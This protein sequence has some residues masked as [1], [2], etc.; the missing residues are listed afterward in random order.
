MFIVLLKNYI[1]LLLNLVQSL[2]SIYFNILS[3]V[4]SL[5]YSYGNLTP[6]RTNFHILSQF[7]DLSC[8]LLKTSQLKPIIIFPFLLPWDLF[9]PNKYLARSASLRLFQT[10]QL[11]ASAVQSHGLCLVRLTK[12]LT[13]SLGPIGA[14]KPRASKGYTLWSCPWCHCIPEPSSQCTLLTVARL[15]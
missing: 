2:C 9:Q 11:C 13:V 4:D 15:F 1:I 14:V 7:S 5:I 12:I 10:P 3:G 6:G 8:A